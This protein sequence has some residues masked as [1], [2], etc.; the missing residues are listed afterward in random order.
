MVDI[1]DRMHS[2]LSKNQTHKHTHIVHDIVQILPL[3]QRELE[4]KFNATL[5]YCICRDERVIAWI[6]M[7]WP[8]NLIA[9]K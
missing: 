4:Y 6:D 5:G 7:A 1:H 3:F 8:G 2:E 9:R